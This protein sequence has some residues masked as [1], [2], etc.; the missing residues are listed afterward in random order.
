[1]KLA[2][3]RL[4][5]LDWTRLLLS[6]HRHASESYVWGA[7]KGIVYKDIPRPLLEME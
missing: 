4:M 2:V 5:G 1:M 6:T 3:S 7:K